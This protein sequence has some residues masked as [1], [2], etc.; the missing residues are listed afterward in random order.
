[1]LTINRN[2]DPS[3]ALQTS[4]LDW[5]VEK[6]PVMVWSQKSDERDYVVSDS[7]MA[8]VRTDTED[9]L[10]VVSDRYQ[11]IQNEELLWCAEK[12]GKGNLSFVSAGYTGNGERVYAQ[13]NGN[14]WGIGPKDDE[15]YPTFVL[16]NGHDGNHPISGWPT[17]IR[18][19]CE[20]TLNMSSSQASRRGHMMISLRHRGTAVDLLES[21]INSVV[22]FQERSDAFHSRAQILA[23]CDLNVEQVQGFWTSVYTKMFGKIY[24]NAATEDQV[25]ANDKAAE[26]MIKWAN[27]FDSEKNHSGTNL[28]TAMNSVTNWL[29]HGQ[30]YRGSNKSDNRFNDTVFGSGA[31]EKVKVMD[32]ALQ[33]I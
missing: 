10:G 26:V 32:L 33:Y 14:P 8:T 4:G 19:I 27:T 30:I 15:V 6:R 22:E 12:I 17:T 13:L 16:S 31:S 2:I 25:K 5:R 29:D 24:S 18:V 11:P 9:I 21:M 3:N 1:M 23:G 20:N 28:W 7:L